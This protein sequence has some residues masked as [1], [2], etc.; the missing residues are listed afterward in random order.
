MVGMET[1]EIPVRPESF[2]KERM[3]N[4]PDHQQKPK[5]ESP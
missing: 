1:D 5:I 4:G 2:A 3:Q